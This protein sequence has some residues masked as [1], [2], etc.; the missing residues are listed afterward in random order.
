MVAGWNAS[1]VRDPLLNN[2]NL[3]LQ[4]RISPSR[5][6]PTRPTRPPFPTPGATMPAA[7]PDTPPPRPP[8]ASAIPRIDRLLRRM[9][10]CPETF[11]IRATLHGLRDRVEYWVMNGGCPAAW[12]ASAETA[13]QGM[14]T[15]LDA[16]LS[17]PPSE[18]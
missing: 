11:E 18:A 17:R 14:E 9:P 4:I 12:R 7:P 13:L 6:N 1:R 3:I 10:P 2:H 5:A 8:L 15:G 16:L